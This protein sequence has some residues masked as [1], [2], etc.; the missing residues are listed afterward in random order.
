MVC[1]FQ[2][3]TLIINSKGLLVDDL[4]GRVVRGYKLLE[5]IGRGGFGAVYKAEHQDIPR[6]VAIKIIHPQYA[7]EPSYIRRFELEAQIVAKLDHIHIVPL[8]DYWREA[9]GAYLV[10]RYLRVVRWKT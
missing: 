8:F 7:N 9:D 10:M 1:C 6:Q 5:C 3:I 2:H 4:T